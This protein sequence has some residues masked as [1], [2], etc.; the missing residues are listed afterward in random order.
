M[1]IV[2]KLV[3]IFEAQQISDSF[4]KREFVVE[5]A[6]N[7]Q[8]PELIKFELI[9]D[10]CS[11]LDSFSKGNEVDVSFNFDSR[12]SPQSK[13]P[14]NKF[15]GAPGVERLQ[16]R[17]RL[18]QET[19]TTATPSKARGR[20]GA[21]SNDPRPDEVGPWVI[22]AGVTRLELAASS[23]TGVLTVSDAIECETP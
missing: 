3:E 18:G 1:N 7:P 10:K 17:Q 6:E 8:Y 5:Y 21:P 15:S 4:K 9:Q 12:E 2:G 20:R 23:L 13:V 11:L 19:T 16:T 14:S 22:V